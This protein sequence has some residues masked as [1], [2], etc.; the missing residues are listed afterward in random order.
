MKNMDNKEEIPPT[1]FISYSHDSEEHKTWV[2]Q[3]AT[4]LYSNGVNVLLDV[5][6]L[7]LGKDV[8]SFMERGLTEANR[9]ICVCSNKY[10]EKSNNG[11]GGAGYEKQ[12]MTAELVGDQNTDLIIPLIKNNTL[13]R[14]TPTFLAGRMYINFDDEILYEKNYWDI[15]RDI[16]KEPVFPVP[17]I[18]SNPFKN[19]RN[20]SQ[21]KLVPTNEK[22]LSPAMNGKVTFDY[23]NNNHMYTVGCNELM[24]EV[25][26]SNASN[27][28]IHLYNDPNSILSIARVKDVTEINEIADARN[29]DTS[30]RTRTIK[31][32]EIALMQNIN[33]FYCAIKVTAISAESHGAENDIV[34][35]EYFIQTN[36]SPDFTNYKSNW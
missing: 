19:I 29:Y 3:L 24:F 36:G 17:T 15:L 33:G 30:S 14:K 26:W 11:K 16:H 18:G 10:V 31:L 7:S 21:E 5:W 25:R 6:N 4:R 20:F 22:Y 32:N 28:S 8:A 1:V 13:T 34:T 9:I 2:L 23:S 12:I 27:N 35:F